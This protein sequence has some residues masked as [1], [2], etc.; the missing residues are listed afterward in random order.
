M[1]RGDL[2]HSFTLVINGS[3]LVSHLS[4][5]SR[6]QAR[7]QHQIKPPYMLFSSAKNVTLNNFKKATEFELLRRSA[8]KEE[9]EPYLRWR[10]QRNECSLKFLVLSKGNGRTF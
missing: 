6:R 4:K 3:A 2:V 10:L 1:G 8:L 9:M 7:L 5:V